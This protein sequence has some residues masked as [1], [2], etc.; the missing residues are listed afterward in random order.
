MALQNKAAVEDAHR[1]AA[2]RGALIDTV[3]RLNRD[4]ARLEGF[5]RSLIQH[6]QEDGE[7][8]HGVAFTIVVDDDGD[9][10]AVVLHPAMCASHL[11]GWMD[12]CALPHTSPP[13]SRFLWTAP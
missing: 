13:C 8:R 6:L 11:H 4:I 2:E 3:K 7:V 10:S 1:L 5:K 9:V 12:V